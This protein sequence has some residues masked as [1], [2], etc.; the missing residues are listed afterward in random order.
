MEY[1][2]LDSLKDFIYNKNDNQSSLFVT[3]MQ[4]IYK[5]KLKKIILE[6]VQ[7]YRN[8]K[9]QDSNEV[10]IFNLSKP[11]LSEI[12]NITIDEKTL[13]ACFKNIF[14]KLKKSAIKLFSHWMRSN[15]KIFPAFLRRIG[16]ILCLN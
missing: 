1:N 3:E 11:K 7:F 16:Q 15:L 6:T 2:D 10:V 9:Y 5:Q 12:N 8:K 4:K 13:I 14:L